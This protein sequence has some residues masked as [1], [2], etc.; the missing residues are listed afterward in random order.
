[1]N[2][3]Q[4]R[5]ITADGI[6]ELAASLS[7]GR[8]EAL[9]NYL[10]TMSCF[11]RYS[12]HNMM[13]IPLQKPTASRVAGFHTWQKLGRFV[14]KGEKGIVILAPLVRH[15]PVVQEVQVEEVTP[16]LYG[17]RA[18][19]VFDVTQTEGRDL[20]DIGRVLGEPKAYLT[21]LVKLVLESGIALDYSVEIGPA[22][23]TSPG[24][25]I[26]LL[27]GMDPA[28]EFS[29]LVHELAH[30]L[31]HRTERRKNTTRS[32]RETEAEAVSH[33]VCR[34]LQI[35]HYLRG[36]DCRSR[37]RVPI[38][39]FLRRQGI[40]PTLTPLEDI[41]INSCGDLFRFLLRV[42]RARQCLPKVVE[43]M[44][45]HFRLGGGILC[46]VGHLLE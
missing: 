34:C 29:T 28:R 30:E 37:Q 1:M 33:V 3:E 7:A 17:F 11:H 22:F 42:G 31:L 5:K 26:T 4:I 39:S 35:G 40:R 18:T 6:E 27:P 43:D 14:K 32:M 12:L 25:K 46:P 21:R 15:K 41:V 9:N 20:P 8:S 10:A 2:Q 19:Y 24:S 13:L 23:G 36:Y 38:S 44:Y 45:L 16:M